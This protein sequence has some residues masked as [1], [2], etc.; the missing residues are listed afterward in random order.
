MRH[1]NPS[2]MNALGGDKLAAWKRL[3]DEC[4]AELIVSPERAA[5][6]LRRYPPQEMGRPGIIHTDSHDRGSEAK[7]RKAD[8]DPEPTI[9]ERLAEAWRVTFEFEGKGNENLAD[10]EIELAVAAD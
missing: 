3:G 4:L 6:I 1:P 5:W 10:E 2:K 9:D 7:I 8:A